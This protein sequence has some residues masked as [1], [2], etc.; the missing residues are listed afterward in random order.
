MVDE[1]RPLVT[2]GRA[3]D[4]IDWC[5]RV[6]EAVYE[7]AARPEFRRQGYPASLLSARLFS[8]EIPDMQ[9]SLYDIGQLPSRT[10]EEKRRKSLM[11]ALQAMS[12]Y[13]CL[14]ACDVVEHPSRW[15][16]ADPVAVPAEQLRRHIHDWWIGTCARPL[17]AEH[18]EVL[19]ALNALSARLEEGIVWIDPVSSDHLLTT[20]RWD[21]E[22]RLRVVA[23]EL[24]Q[25]G[26]ILNDVADDEADWRLSATYYG[27]VWETRQQITRYT[28]W[29]DDLVARWETTS[30]DFKRELRVEMDNEKSELVK[31]L[32][33]LVNTQANEPH[34]LVIGFDPVTHGY[35]GPSATDITQDRLEAIVNRYVEPSLVFE[36]A[37][38]GYRAGPVGIL[39]VAREPAK[40]PYRFAIAIG[41]GDKRREAGVW[42]VRH[43]SQTEPPTPRERDA[44]ITEGRRARGEPGTGV[45]EEVTEQWGQIERRLGNSQDMGFWE[46]YGHD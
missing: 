7:G 32:L 37:V 10:R 12:S 5:T 38:V 46:R 40:L 29:I 41:S 20:L 23:S 28:P 30:V 18:I 19:R 8:E 17:P 44:I 14:I 33:G 2:D 31:D 15:K 16:P 21:D 45:A 39:A 42:F 34:L 26:H 1:S 11:Q 6:V 13:P 36:Y 3:M 43:G 25:H 35:H 27:L 24:Y 22:E 9:V 4:F